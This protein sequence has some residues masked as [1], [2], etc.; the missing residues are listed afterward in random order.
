MSLSSTH[1]RSVVDQDGA[2]ILDM[3]R[4]AMSTLNSTGAYVWDGLQRG[5]SIDEIIE[6]LARETGTDR[7]LVDQDVHAF[8]HD[9]KL[10]HLMPH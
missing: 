7:L 10:K 5:Q 9:L 8:M 4:N 1:L 3:E 2:V 6:S